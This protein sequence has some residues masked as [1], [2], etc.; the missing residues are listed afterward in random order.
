MGSKHLGLFI[1]TERSVVFGD[2]TRYHI[3]HTEV[4]TLVQKSRPDEVCAIGEDEYGWYVSA[5]GFTLTLI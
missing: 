5:P 2:I 4:L 1:E 3:N